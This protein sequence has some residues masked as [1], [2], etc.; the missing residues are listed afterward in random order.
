VSPRIRLRPQVPDEVLAIARQI[1]EHNPS[2]AERFVELLPLTLAGL[3]VM[4]G[5]GSHK[6]F[7]NPRLADVRTW[8]VRGFPNFLIC[9]RPIEDGIEVLAI[10]HGARDV[11]RLL[12]ERTK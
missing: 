7:R 1:I 10:T 4:P 2:A 8:R 11:R 9:Y 6:S 12:S 5:K 3:A